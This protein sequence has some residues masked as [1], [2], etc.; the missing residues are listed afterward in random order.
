[1]NIKWKIL[2]ISALAIVLTIY[3]ISDPETNAWFPKCLF[4]NLTGLQCPSCGTQR[5]LHSVLN[6][7]FV[8]AFHYNPFLAFA[9]PYFSGIIYAK[10]FNGKIAETL[11]K[12]LLNRYSIYS[13]IAIY[14][15][16]G[17][18]RNIFHI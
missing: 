14:F 6:G 2:T 13:Y 15:L 16:W 1:M 11:E 5:A 17:I 12:F 9:I 7:E 3:V 18:T 8:K 4:F 10:C